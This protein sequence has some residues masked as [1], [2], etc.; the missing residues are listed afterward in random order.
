MSAS[1][2]RILGVGLLLICVGS[3]IEASDSYNGT[4]SVGWMLA[5]GATWSL[6]VWL[7]PEH[8]STSQ[9]KRW[10]RFRRKKRLRKQRLAITQAMRELGFSEEIFVS[11]LNEGISLH[12]G[13]LE[14]N[15]AANGWRKMDYGDLVLA[16]EALR[17]MMGMKIRHIKRAEELISKGS[18]SENSLLELARERHPCLG[19]W[20]SMNHTEI[21][22]L[23][24]L[25]TGTLPEWVKNT[26][27]N[28]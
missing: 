19:D 18:V 14:K 21:D 1:R 11:A 12:D 10:M 20:R 15:C 4:P 3:M 6:V 16:Q 27:A 23:I 8:L 9:A 13:R 25:K 17:I 24:G 28:R 7:W 5:M 26:I 22:M 2:K